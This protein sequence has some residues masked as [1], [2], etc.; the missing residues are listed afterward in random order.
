MSFGKEKTLPQDLK[1]SKLCRSK[2]FRCRKLAFYSVESSVVKRERECVRV[3]LCP[4]GERRRE[5]FFFFETERRREVDI[6]SAALL[7]ISGVYVLACVFKKGTKI[8]ILTK[9]WGVLGISSFMI[10]KLLIRRGKRNSG[11]VW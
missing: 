6:R 4:A 1:M 5:V 7:H 2:K 10:S 9:Y 3:R 11:L 8:G